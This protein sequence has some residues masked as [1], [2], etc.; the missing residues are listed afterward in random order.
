MRLFSIRQN[1]TSC[2]CF[3][4][5]VT[6]SC[7]FFV[8]FV[9]VAVAAAVAVAV[10]V[11]AVAV[12][13][14]VVVAVAVAV[15]VVVVVVAKNTLDPFISMI[16]PFPTFDNQPTSVPLGV[17]FVSLPRGETLSAAASGSSQPSGLRSLENDENGGRNGRWVAENEW[18]K[19][20]S[21]GSGHFFL[22]GK[23]I[24]IFLFWGGYE[25]FWM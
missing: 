21:L 25:D 8:F 15:A 4:F 12:A 1:P 20:T 14:A 11:V 3:G 9:A 6:L 16:F 24:V 13:V 7:F 23:N 17:F 10:A 5:N 19:R 2:F 18:M 22:E